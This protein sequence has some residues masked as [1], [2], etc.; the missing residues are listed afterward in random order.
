M[1]LGKAET[2]KPD[3]GETETPGKGKAETPG[4]SSLWKSQRR[5]AS[6]VSGSEADT[7]LTQSPAATQ[8]SVPQIL[9]NYLA[10][11]VSG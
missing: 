4:Y 8:Q 3:Q 6:R 9:G 2:E 7:W 10:S 1:G 11:R 5:L